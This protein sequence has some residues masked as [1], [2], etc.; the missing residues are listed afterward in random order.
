MQE[1]RGSVYQGWNEDLRRRYIQILDIVIQNLKE[2]PYY[3]FTITKVDILKLME[4]A[5]AMNYTI[6]EDNDLRDRE[7]F[8]NVRGEII[9]LAIK[10]VEEVLKPTDPYAQAAKFLQEFDLRQ[11]EGEKA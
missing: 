7:T 9:K 11:L 5:K 3:P 8:F 2:T 4:C 10:K 6:D 1:S